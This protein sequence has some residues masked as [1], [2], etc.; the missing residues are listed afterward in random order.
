[1]DVASIPAPKSRVKQVKSV[2]K[3]YVYLT[4]ISHLSCLK[5]LKQEF[6]RMVRHFNIC[7]VLICR[8]IIFSRIVRGN[9]SKSASSKSILMRP[10][11]GTFFKI[12]MENNVFRSQLDVGC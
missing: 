3:K 8:A 2:R 7:L 11:F 5:I 4:V 10:L 1:M 6:W 9:F 12:L